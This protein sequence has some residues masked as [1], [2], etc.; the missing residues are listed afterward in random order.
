[1][2]D[3]LAFLDSLLRMSREGLTASTFAASADSSPS[4][5]DSNSSP[6]ED[7]SLGRAAA[8]E[9]WEMFSA[10]GATTTS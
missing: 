5:Q 8:I 6:K 4:L 7:D 1:M 9:T 10:S 3:S 2:D